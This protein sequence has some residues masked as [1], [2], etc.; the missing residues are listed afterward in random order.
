MVHN[1]AVF[2]QEDTYRI[3]SHLF[4]SDFPLACI[5]V[6][7]LIFFFFALPFFNIFFYHKHAYRSRSWLYLL[8]VCPSFFLII[9]FHQHVYRIS[10]SSRS[11]LFLLLSAYV[12]N[13][14][15]CYSSG[16]EDVRAFLDLFLANLLL[17]QFYAT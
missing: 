6:Q 2:L 14:T 15:Y 11:V 5:T 3:H 4:L 9:F 1:F 16:K 8:F 17:T 7:F 12:L 10:C 13:I